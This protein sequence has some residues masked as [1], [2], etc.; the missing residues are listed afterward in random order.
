MSSLTSLMTSR[1]RLHLFGPLLE[2]VD[3][4]VD[5]VDK[6]CRFDTLAECLPQDGLGLGHC[7]LDRVDNHERAVDGTHCSGH[8]ATEVDVARRVDQ[9]DKVVGILV[10]VGHRNVCRIDGDPTFL[11]VFFGVHRELLSGRL[12][13][14]HASTSK[15]VV[16]KRRFTVVDVCGDGD[17]P[18]VLRVVHQPLTFLNDLFSSA[19]YTGSYQKEGQKGSVSPSKSSPDSDRSTAV[20][21]AFSVKWRTIPCVVV[22]RRPTPDRAATSCCLRLGSRLRAPGSSSGRYSRRSSCRRNGRP[23]PT[24]RR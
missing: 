12:V 24:N 3:E 11:L 1:S 23:Q 7:A 14:D 22:E 5:L 15:E 6:E 9:V 13:G 19:H 2:L 17:V 10:L 20:Y 4:A 18:D 8:V 16:R 21:C